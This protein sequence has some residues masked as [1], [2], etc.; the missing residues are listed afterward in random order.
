MTAL[1]NI[2]LI[3]IGLA[4]IMLGILMYINTSESKHIKSVLLVTC[5]SGGLW[6][7]G[8]ALETIYATSLVQLYCRYLTLLAI[9]VFFAGAVLFLHRIGD[10][11]FGDFFDRSIDLYIIFTGIVSY[12]FIVIKS[13]I[14]MGSISAEVLGILPGGIEYCYYFSLGAISIYF[15]L[16]SYKKSKKTRIKRMAAAQLFCIVLMGALY[17]T[18]RL[19]IS[20][21]PAI[22]RLGAYATLIIQVLFIQQ[23]WRYNQVVLDKTRVAEVIYNTVNTPVLQL[24]DN[25]NIKECNEYALNYMSAQKSEAIGQKITEFITPFSNERLQSIKAQL[26]NKKEEIS[27]ET[28]IRRTG[29]ECTAI[30]SVVYDRYKEVVYMIMVLNDHTQI[31]QMKETM[32]TAEKKLQMANSSKIA[33]LK[34][35]DEDIK[36]PISETLRQCRSIL[37]E[38]E[39]SVEAAEKVLRIEEENKN[40]QRLIDDMINI[41]H[42]EEGTFEIEKSKYDFGQLLEEII[43]EAAEK[44]DENNVKFITQISP[45]L[46]RFLI[47]D[48][49]RLKQMLNIFLSNAICFTE[50]G[51]ITLFVTYR[52]RFGKI[53]LQFRISD[54]GYG[55]AEEDV[56]YIIGNFGVGENNPK[57]NLG[58]GLELTIARNIVKLMD[59]EIKVQSALGRGSVFSFSVDQLTYSE[60]SIVPYKD[61]QSKLLVLSCNQHSLEALDRLLKEIG[62]ESV[63]AVP[64]DFQTIE[65][66]KEQVD[67]IIADAGIIGRMRPVLFREY[68]DIPMISI[69]TYKNFTKMLEIENGIC[70][71]LAYSQ[72]GKY[73]K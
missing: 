24:D 12:I 3:L 17:I 67:I 71:P 18:E 52:I 6:A 26:I 66:P 8:T 13:I 1:F 63:T 22:F 16:L 32:E 65:L 19:V 45:S 30:V 10:F 43:K 11:V 57:A 73:L 9:Y 28:Q 21:Q 55:I 14:S 23:Y 64:V 29:F 51:Y 54:T 62:V 33:F 31:T 42:M 58:K 48:G 56:D 35:L 40:L 20:P 4:D 70:E 41:A 59:G 47:G 39:L 25:W 38:T 5:I 15:V 53:T 46:P 27:F 68:G 49:N 61:Y 50:S 34:S 7:F 44:I 72:I 60:N 69:Y 36:N 2:I 37:E